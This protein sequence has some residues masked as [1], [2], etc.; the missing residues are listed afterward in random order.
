MKSFPSCINVYGF[1]VPIL[2][3][4]NSVKRKNHGLVYL[5]FKIRHQVSNS[6]LLKHNGKPTPD[7][8]YYFDSAHY[9]YPTM[10]SYFI[11]LLIDPTTC[12]SLSH[13]HCSEVNHSWFVNK[14]T[15]PRFSETQ[16]KI[17]KHNFFT[18]DQV[19]SFMLF[20]SSLNKSK[21]L[22][23]VELHFKYEKVKEEMKDFII[24]LSLRWSI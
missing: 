24:P 16:T 14:E 12:K 8:V 4:S 9:I 17:N 10:V 23:Q 19:F 2:E 11:Y 21:V 5:N 22:H 13:R 6:I 3:L 15:C 1:W 7:S 18:K 20:D